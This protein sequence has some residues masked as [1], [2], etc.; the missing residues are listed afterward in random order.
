MIPLNL[1]TDPALWRLAALFVGSMFGIVLFGLGL[2]HASVRQR[3]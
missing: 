2:M 3:S 1:T